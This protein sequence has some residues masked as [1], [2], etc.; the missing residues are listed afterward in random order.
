MH[1]T[2][3]LARLL[4]DRGVRCLLASFGLTIYGFGTYLQIQ[5]NMGLSPWNALSQGLADQ[6]GWTFGNAS[7]L[8][9]LLVIAVD[10]LLREPI[11][12]GTLLDAVLVGAF[13]DLYDSW[14]ILPVLENFWLGLAVMVAGLAVLAYSEY[15]YKSACLGCGPRDALMVGVGK[16]LKRLPIGMV[17]IVI[18]LAVCGVGWLLGG[19]VGVGTLIFLVCNGLVMQAVFRLIRFEPRDLT[20]VGLHQML[21]RK[22]RLPEES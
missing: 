11:G 2:P 7:I 12:V 21:T 5:A 1:F 22:A 10:L 18:S 6:M 3:S 14:G 16:R 15:M 19:S 20:H 17:S 8:I 9:S 4:R 13:Y